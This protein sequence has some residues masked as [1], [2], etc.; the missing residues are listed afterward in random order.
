MALCFALLA[1]L[2]LGCEVATAE[3]APLPRPRPAMAA[4]VTG[5]L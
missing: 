4:A 1:C 5:Q 3:E 2:L